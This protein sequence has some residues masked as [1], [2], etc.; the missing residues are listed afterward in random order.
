[1]DGR[2]WQEISLKVTANLGL[3]KSMIDSSMQSSNLVP[4]TLGSSFVV[5]IS[6]KTTRFG[7]KMLGKPATH[8]KFSHA[9]LEIDLEHQKVLSGGSYGP[10]LGRE[11]DELTRILSNSRQS[12]WFS[13]LRFESRVYVLVPCLCCVARGEVSQEREEK[14]EGE[15]NE[16]EVREFD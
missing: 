6:S 13:D 12:L 16:R 3:Y 2:R 14:D 9:R 10:Y 15:R 7:Q 5:S 11:G 8:S 4:G 1:M